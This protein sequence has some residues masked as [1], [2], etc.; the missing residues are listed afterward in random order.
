VAH[1][2]GEKGD[3]TKHAFSETGIIYANNVPYLISIMTEGKDQSKLPSVIQD[4][5]TAVYNNIQ[6]MTQ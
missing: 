4:I 3:E 2:F 1:K 6:G 5:S